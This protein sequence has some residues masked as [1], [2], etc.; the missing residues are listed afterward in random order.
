MQAWRF[1][2]SN[3]YTAVMIDTISRSLVCLT[4]ISCRL[5]GNRETR[6]GT[7]NYL[8][9]YKKANYIFVPFSDGP[10]TDT[11]APGTHFSL[12]IFDI[13]EKT[14]EWICGKPVCGELH[15]LTIPQTIYEI[16][17]GLSW[18]LFHGRT[19]LDERKKFELKTR[20]SSTRN[21]NNDNA[22]TDSCTCGPFVINVIQWFVHHW[23]LGED[24]GCISRYLDPDEADQYSGV[25]G[26]QVWYFSS[27]NTRMWLYQ[28]IKLYQRVGSPHIYFRKHKQL[29]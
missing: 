17:E 28:C 19:K 11:G 15:P 24:L 20:W 7:S 12:L 8:K 9:Q 13:R 26:G 10:S 29:N 18:L 14:V 6:T 1:F 23:C 3:T 2:A 27:F 21:L 5:V 22:C 25:P 16:S 4:P